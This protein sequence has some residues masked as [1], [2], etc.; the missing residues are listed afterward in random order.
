MK[1][2]LCFFLGHRSGHSLFRYQY[3]GPIQARQYPG[4]S[5]TVVACGF[6]CL[7]CGAR[8]VEP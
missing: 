5:Y 4:R 8:V 7:R 1:R 3:D 6:E 2:L